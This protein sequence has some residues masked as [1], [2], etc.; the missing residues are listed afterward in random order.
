[1]KV[2]R[3]RSRSGSVRRLV[4][5]VTLATPL[6]LALARYGR[7]VVVQGP[8]GLLLATHYRGFVPAPRAPAVTVGNVV[9]LRM[10]EQ[11]AYRRRGLLEHESRHATQ[12]ACWLG[13]FGFLPAY[14]IASLWSLLRAGN[15]ATRNAF[16]VRAG[17]ADGGYAPHPEA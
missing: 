14:G 8:D 2:D 1:M 16:E 12:W 17:L 15:A 5:A 13:P 4:N 9:L 11:D 6:G 10:S 3:L 7:A